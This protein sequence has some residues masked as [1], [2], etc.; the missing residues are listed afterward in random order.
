MRAGLEEGEMVVISA[1]FLIDSES[2]LKE[3]ITKMLEAKKDGAADNGETDGME[4]M[5]HG[6]GEM[7]GMD[8][9]SGEMEG[10]DHSGM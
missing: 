5:D 1:Q 10:M 2:R 3:A 7:E 9:G 4:G 6:S 8:H